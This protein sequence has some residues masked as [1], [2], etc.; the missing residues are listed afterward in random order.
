VI[1]TGS[2]FNDELEHEESASA[3][4]H[5]EM[6]MRQQ[7]LQSEDQKRQAELLRL[8]EQNERIPKGGSNIRKL[9][10]MAEIRK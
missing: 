1:P 5:Q 6:V 9:I 2:N 10:K 7:Q 8:Q 3:I 4:A